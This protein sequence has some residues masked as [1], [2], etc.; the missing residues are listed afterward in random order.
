MKNSSIL[1][2]KLN[3]IEENEPEIELQEE[4]L[5]TFFANPEKHSQQELID[6]IIDAVFFNKNEQ[7]QLMKDP[8]V[9]LLIPNRPGHYNFTV[10][11]AMG[12]ITEGKHGTELEAAIKRLY[13]ERGITTIRADT[14]TA[15]SF[16]FNA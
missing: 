2:N 8:L 11:S 6:A 10:I 3:A 13:K 7:E 9:R 16:E 1:L 5:P 15:R 4:S 12:V 14:G